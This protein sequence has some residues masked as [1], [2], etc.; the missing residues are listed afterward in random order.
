MQTARDTSY[1]QVLTASGA[2]ILFC[3]LVCSPSHAE[4]KITH[5]GGGA[6]KPPVKEPAQELS[7]I[8]RRDLL[9]ALTDTDLT[10]RL[11]AQWQLRMLGDRSLSPDLTNLLDDKRPY[12][13]QLA[14]ELLGEVGD[15]NCL[16]AVTRTLLE[17]PDLRVRETA[18]RTL[19]VI[20]DRSVVAALV[21]AINQPRPLPDTIGYWLFPN[22]IYD[23]YRY[24]AA[25]TLNRIT[26]NNFYLR[27]NA[28]NFDR[29]SAQNEINRWWK[30]NRLFYTKEIDDII[31]TARQFMQA[32]KDLKENVGKQ[33]T[34][35]SA[36]MEE[37]ARHLDDYSDR[38]K[39]AY[40]L[41]AALPAK[42]D[43]IFAVFRELDDLTTSTD[44]IFVFSP[45]LSDLR[46]DWEQVNSLRKRLVTQLRN[47]GV[48]EESSSRSSSIK[49]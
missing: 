31:G 22:D 5:F 6:F 3:A 24:A 14:C 27:R 21:E 20:G 29:I 32:A 12:V 48:Q 16:P 13:R 25:E 30:A 42:K 19:T 35:K 10:K 18:A 8:Q 43:A 9:N 36:G 1:R 47:A 2:L 38:A 44:E 40:A 15:K 46:G 39:D 49:K 7:K 45:E 4:E 28:T 37:F 33:G 11:D 23:N 34:A 26:R 17:D 41:T